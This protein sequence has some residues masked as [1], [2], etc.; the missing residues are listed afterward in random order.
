[1]LK[2]LSNG[3]LLI[4]ENWAWST[5]VSSPATPPV[6]P[7]GNV[8]VQDVDFVQDFN[9]PAPP[10]N[11]FWRVGLLNGPFHPVFTTGT[12]SVVLAPTGVART[13][14]SAFLYNLKGEVT[15]PIIIPLTYPNP[16]LSPP[17]QIGTIE[18][19]QTVVGTSTTRDATTAISGDGI[20]WSL[21]VNGSPPFG[22]WAINSA[23]VITVPTVSAYS[24]VVV[25][26]TGTNS[27]GSVSTTFSAVVI[28]ESSGPV[29]NTTLPTFSGPSLSVGTLWTVS[30]AVWSG[31]VA[32]F[33]NQ[34]SFFRDNVA[35]TPFGSTPSY[36]LQAADFGHTITAQERRT[37]SVGSTVA[38]DAVGSA[39][40]PAVPTFTRP[41]E[42]GLRNAM[43]N[44]ATNNLYGL[45]RYGETPW[46]DLTSGSGVNDPNRTHIM[47]FVAIAALSGMTTVNGGKTPNQR[48][49]DQLVEWANNGTM[50]T[51]DS[52]YRSQYEIGFVSTVAIARLIPTV[53]DGL[54]TTQ[55]NRLTAGMKG[56]MVGSAWQQSLTNPFGT[57]FARGGNRTIRGYQSALY[58]APNYT[59]G[60]KSIPFIVA[61]F[62]GVSQAKTFLNTFNRATFA[63]ELQSL[64]G[65]TSMYNTFNGDW[66]E[67][68][69]QAQQGSPPAVS[70]P[71]PTASQLAGAINNWTTKV[72]SSTPTLTLDDVDELFI[73]AID[74]CFSKVI[75]VGPVGYRTN[76]NDMGV[77][78]NSRNPPQLRAVI[79]NQ[80][81]W[82]GLPNAGQIGMWEEL[83]TI[84]GGYTPNL[85]SSMSYSLKGFTALT[86]ALLALIA[87]GVINVNAPG[88]SA[89]LAKMN[90]G[91]KDLRYRTENGHLSYAKGGPPST[92]NENHPENDANSRWALTSRYETG[93]IVLRSLGVTP[94]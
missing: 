80:A 76:P 78:D 72:R 56:C 69:N 6:T 75:R 1:M 65:L 27:S 29:V 45:H 66:T 93:D 26:V 77:I 47:P 15:S 11:W 59:I 18:N 64:G 51:G 9:F 32:P 67:A 88:M 94:L 37:D 54:T 30:G 62:M 24:S 25:T 36:R 46:D 61:N 7:V 90:R 39:I 21:L 23:G 34:W 3:A 43:I 74:R 28:S 2:T 83:D 55:R 49:T 89:A 84:N 14:A 53:W 20:V 42:A 91:L 31:G 50:P 58:N 10:T 87:Q 35:I 86:C 19:V 92:N 48:I 81:A 52:G 13:A 79:T 17:V 82:A 70:G 8:R 73:G 40:V 16:I 63:S 5:P 22:G 57:D 44:P 71:G 68:R 12:T 4:G 41:T 60:A 85:R 33:T 38:V